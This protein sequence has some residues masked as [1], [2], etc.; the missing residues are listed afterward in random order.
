MICSDACSK[1]DLR[2][3]HRRCPVAKKKK[4]SSKAAFKNNATREFISFLFSDTCATA[5][6]FKVLLARQG[7]LAAAAAGR[8]S[9]SS[10]TAPQLSLQPKL[11]IRGL[12]GSYF[13]TLNADNDG[14]AE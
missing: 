6:V 2:R 13:H 10:G 14:R 7:D 3:L 8:A 1:P 11:N 12:S 5:D 9:S 4:S